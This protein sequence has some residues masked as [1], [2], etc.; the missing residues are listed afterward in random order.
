[1]RSQKFFWKGNRKN[2]TQTQSSFK[3]S[4]GKLKKVFW[5]IKFCGDHHIRSQKFFWKGNRFHQ[6]SKFY[7]K[8][9]FSRGNGCLR[10]GS[11]LLAPQGRIFLLYLLPFSRYSQKTENYGKFYPM[12]RSPQNLIFLKTFLGLGPNVAVSSK[13][14]FPEDFFGFGT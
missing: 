2:I 6:N 5:K 12:W 9:V 1:M 3:K 11:A 13:F 14:N 10:I 8:L 7:S 4:S